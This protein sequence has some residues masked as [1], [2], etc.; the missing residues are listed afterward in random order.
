MLIN[1]SAPR[2]VK[3]DSSISISFFA[4]GLMLR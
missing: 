4:L 1:Q 2:V 3:N